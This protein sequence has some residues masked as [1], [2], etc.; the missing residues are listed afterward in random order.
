M[1][2]PYLRIFFNKFSQQQKKTHKI[3]VLPL[4]FLSG[5]RLLDAVI[6]IPFRRLLCWGTWF[7][8]NHWGWV[9][10]WAGW[11]SRSF[12]TLVI[13]WFPLE[14]LKSKLAA[15]C[16]TSFLCNKSSPSAFQELLQSCPSSLCAANRNI[17]NIT[18]WNVLGIGEGMRVLQTKKGLLRQGS[19]GE[20]WRGKCRAVGL[21]P[22]AVTVGTVTDVEQ[23][24]KA[25]GMN[26]CELLLMEAI[27]LLSCFHES[28]PGCM[29]SITPWCPC[30]V[31]I[32]RRKS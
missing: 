30:Q 9:N 28:A 19:K 16:V 10:V 13:L 32:S 20:N 23:A 12:P 24:E 4:L 3:H 15:P 27:S 11:S 5:L 22:T 8:E 25:V 6:E 1:G 26:P 14:L 17:K 31:C 2:D 21:C 18:S 29:L 7:S